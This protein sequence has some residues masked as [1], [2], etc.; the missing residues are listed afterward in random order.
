MISKR[1]EFMNIPSSELQLISFFWGED[2]WEV[3]NEV[4]F[5]ARKHRCH[6]HIQLN[7]AQSG[8]T[9]QETRV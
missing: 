6:R 3:L 7:S 8:R 4:P 1:K 5:E 9:F 2:E